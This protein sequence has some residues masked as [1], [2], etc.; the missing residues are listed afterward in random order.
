MYTP[1]DLVNKSADNIRANL[2]RIAKGYGPCDIVL[3]DIESG[4]PDDRIL[5]FIEECSKLSSQHSA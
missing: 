2:E 5:Y 1:M 4:T 3:A